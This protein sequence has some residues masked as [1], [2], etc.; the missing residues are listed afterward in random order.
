MLDSRIPTRPSITGLTAVVTV[1]EAV[2]TVLTAVVPSA[3]QAQ[4]IFSLLQPISRAKYPELTWNE[5]LIS[6]ALQVSIRA[7]FFL[8]PLF[9]MLS[10]QG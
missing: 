4:S 2:V 6:V 1:F 3:P 9:G 10:C 7:Y 8:F 5:E